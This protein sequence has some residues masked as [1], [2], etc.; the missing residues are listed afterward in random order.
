MEDRGYGILDFE[1]I[2]NMARELVYSVSCEGMMLDDEGNY[3]GCPD[4]PAKWL[5]IRNTDSRFKYLNFRECEELHSITLADASEL[6]SDEIM[7]KYLYDAV[8]FIR[9]VMRKGS[10]TPYQFVRNDVPDE[11][12]NQIICTAWKADLMIWAN[13]WDKDRRKKDTKE[14]LDGE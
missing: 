13:S 6:F 5:E 14:T 8:P 11:Y 4:N 10:L 2:W 3:I 1:A 9:T 12:L 7:E